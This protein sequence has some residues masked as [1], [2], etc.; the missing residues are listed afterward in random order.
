MKTQPLR[1]NI[2][3]LSEKEIKL[4]VEEIVARWNNIIVDF[5]NT[6]IR[7]CLMVKDYL[8]DC[9]DA[10]VK[11]ILKRVRNHPN[12]K[13]FVAIDRIWQGLRLIRNRPDLIEYHL[14][15]EG[16][17]VSLPEDKK[18]YVKKDGEVFWEFYFEL[19]KH[20]LSTAM[21]SY[22]EQEGKRDKWSY[23][24]LK[25]KLMEVKDEMEAGGAYELRRK[26]KYE[27]I[28][29]IAA[30]CKE[31]RVEQLRGVFNFCEEFRKENLKRTE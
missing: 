6:T 29:K 31:L 10:T 24:E 11:E 5:Q 27:L 1:D 12:V 26:E 7:L 16:E 30:V 28:R 21:Q 2:M 15:E 8:K 17:R 14:K 18:P 9:P 19:E 4:K 22:L 3:E 20:P 13:R 23:R 25:T